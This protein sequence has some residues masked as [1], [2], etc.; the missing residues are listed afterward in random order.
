MGLPHKIAVVG[1]GTMGNGIAH[2]FA[3]NGYDVTL[4]DVDPSFLNRAL[5]TIEKNLGRQVKKEKI[6]Q[7]DADAT[8]GRLTFSVYSSCS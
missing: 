1:S 5:T 8:M 6:S 3:K 2:V 4:I 7:A